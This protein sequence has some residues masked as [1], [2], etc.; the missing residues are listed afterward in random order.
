MIDANKS[1]NNNQTNINVVCWGS[2]NLPEQLSGRGECDV[3]A[4]LGKVKQISAGVQHI[5]ALL[6]D[7]TVRCWGDNEFGQCD[8]PNEHFQSPAKQISAGTLTGV[9]DE[10]ELYGWWGRRMRFKI[11]VECPIEGESSQIAMGYQHN[12]LLH[13]DGT[14]RCWGHNK[15]GQCNVPRNLGTVKQVAVSGGN[16]AALLSDGSVRCWG[17]NKF[18]Q[19][20][21]PSDLGEVQQIEMGTY[22]SAA[23]L[24]D[25]SV[26]CWGNNEFGQCD[27][28][29]DLEKVQQIS[30][31]ATHTMALLSDG[32]VRCWGNNKFG[33]CDVPSDL[34]NVKQISAGGF[35]CV[36]LTR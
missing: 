18:G 12:A 22:Y 33:Q 20:V 35:F 30:I 17:D 21:V 14:V 15:H 13:I 5:A 9:V 10:N 36:A 25:G 26:R 32:T 4:D 27:V 28:P 24:S 11:D 31:Q 29:S 34:C 7:G 23:L 19:C 6:T 1:M 16:S 2:K 3:P 8:S